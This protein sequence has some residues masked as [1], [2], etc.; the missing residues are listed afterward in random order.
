[1]VTA[2]WMGTA[3]LLDANGVPVSEV[4]VELWK[5]PRGGRAVWGGMISRVLDPAA[6]L[7]AGHEGLLLALDGQAPVQ[8][9]AAGSAKVVPGTATAALGV[10]GVDA[11]PF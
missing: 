2:H 5:Q 4:S 11:P 10:I 7:P 1:M 9:H 3:D 6:P 8:V